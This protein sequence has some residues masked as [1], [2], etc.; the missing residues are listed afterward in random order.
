[1]RAVEALEQ[2]PALSVVAPAFNEQES[3][4]D[5]V[6]E[7]Y[8][9]L[10][11]LPTQSASSA[12][13]DTAVSGY[14]LICVDDGSTDQTFA[15]LLELQERF[16]RLRAIAL[17]RNHG[18]SAALA[19]GVAVARGQ[20]IALI[21]ADLQN[22]PIDVVRLFALLQ[23]RADVDCYVGVRAKRRDTWLRRV[24]SKIANRIGRWI[25]GEYL[26]D[27]ACGI[28]VCR[29][30]LLKH[31]TFFRGAHRFLATLVRLEGG[32]VHEIDVNHRPR[33]KGESKYGS[34]LGRTFIALRDAFGVRWLKDRKIRYRLKFAGRET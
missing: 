7:M 9:H 10:E 29:A 25:T 2:S 21:D 20:I 31:V 14:E 27:A 8:Q 24:S 6:V 13:A 26:R 11:G 23:S 17:D 3:I 1:M 32:T 30:A 15:R 5:F 22:D 18:Q 12:V 19:A 34:G 33:V 4:E 28:K 16:P